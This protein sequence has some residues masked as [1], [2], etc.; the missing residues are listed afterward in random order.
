MGESKFE[1]WFEEQYGMLP[2]PER[3][4]ALTKE[5]TELVN[6]LSRNGQERTEL[7][8]IQQAWT[9]CLYAWQAKEK[10]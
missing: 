4:R 8:R 3:L 9:D 1:K 7:E 6:K 2:D 10:V 5:S